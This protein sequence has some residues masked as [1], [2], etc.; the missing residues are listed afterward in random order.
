MAMVPLP[1]IDRNL[2]AWLEFKDSFQSI[3]HNNDEISQIQKF[4][5][6][7]A[8]LKRQAAQVIASLYFSASNNRKFAKD[9]K[10]KKC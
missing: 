9:M 5:Y 1:T 3:I 4:Q 8:S 2:E 10:V 6:L 7:Q